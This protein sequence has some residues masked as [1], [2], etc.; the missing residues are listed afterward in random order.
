MRSGA[1]KSARLFIIDL[2]GSERVSK[3]GADGQTF[4]EAKAINSSLSILG[5][6]INALSSES[7]KGKTRHVPFRDS[8]LTFLLKDSLSGNDSLFKFQFSFCG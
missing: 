3:S 1:S 8:I 5:N 7:E 6:V 2:A 4:E